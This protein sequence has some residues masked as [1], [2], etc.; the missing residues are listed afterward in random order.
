MRWTKTF[1]LKNIQSQY[2]YA[3]VK[4]AEYLVYA[5]YMILMICLIGIVFHGGL[6]DLLFY[7]ISF[8]SF[9]A[10]LYFIY[11]GSINFAVWFMVVILSLNILDDILK[12]SNVNS[13]QLV[14]TIMEAFLAYILVGLFAVRRGQIRYTT[15]SNVLLVIAHGVIIYYVDYYPHGIPVNGMRYFIGGSIAVLLAGFIV[16]ASAKLN[17]EALFMVETKNEELQTAGEQLEHLV[18]YRTDELEKANRELRELNKELSYLNDYDVLTGVFSRRKIMDLCSKEMASS[19]RAGDPFT[20]AMLDIDFF[21]EVNDHYGHA[22]GDRVLRSIARI[23][24]NQLG[25]RHA[26]G[27]MGGEEFLIIM[28]CTDDAAF[29]RLS[30]IREKIASSII[31][32]K[33]RLQVT[34]S[35]GIAAMQR[36]D[37]VEELISRA[38]QALYTSKKQGRNQISILNESSH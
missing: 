18:R 20:V 1:W 9:G 29:N 4:R 36:G 5:V 34:V 38:D 19:M 24:S 23:S 17:T 12:F 10:V 11:K 2:S 13:E 16:Q 15:V 27:R 22:V 30:S 33:G 14:E 35:I 7:L 28:K 21:K 37:S 6:R 32:P 26:F 31:E 3:I 25:K 8:V